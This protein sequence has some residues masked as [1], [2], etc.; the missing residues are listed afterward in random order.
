MGSIRSMKIIHSEY[1][2]DLI[3]CK[4]VNCLNYKLSSPKD[5][6]STSSEF[7]QRYSSLLENR[8]LLSLLSSESQSFYASLK[9]HNPNYKFLKDVMVINGGFEHLFSMMELFTSQLDLNFDSEAVE[10]MINTQWTSDDI[11]SLYSNCVDRL[12]NEEAV[13]LSKLRGFIVAF[14]FKGFFIRNIGKSK[15]IISVLLSATNVGATYRRIFFNTVMRCPIIMTAV[16]SSFQG[17]VDEYMLQNS[18]KFPHSNTTKDFASFTELL[19]KI[20]V[21]LVPPCRLCFS[22]EAFSSSIDFRCEAFLYKQFN[23]SFIKIPYILT[24]TF[25]SKFIDEYNSLNF[26]HESNTGFQVQVRREHSYQDFCKIV[27]SKGPGELKRPIKTT[28]EKEEGDDNLG[29]SRELFRLVGD[30]IKNDDVFI[31]VNGVYF[32]NMKTPSDKFKL[33]GR[34]FGVAVLGC[35]SVNIKLP[36]IFLKKLLGYKNSTLMDVDELFPNMYRNYE[37]YIIDDEDIDSLCLTMS[38]S[39]GGKDINIIESGS[40]ID[41]TNANKAEYFKNLAASIYNNPDFQ[42]CVES[43]KSGLTDVVSMNLICGTIET[44]SSL[45]SGVSEIDWEKWKISARCNRDD[46]VIKHFWSVFD[47]LSQK[48]KLKLLV[49]ATSV[50]HVP[51]RGYEAIAVTIT[52]EGTGADLPRAHTCSRTLKLQRYSSKEELK[53]KLLQ[54]IESECFGFK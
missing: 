21:D 29:V 49:F 24:S 45:L 30:G 18:E 34:I 25:I 26:E 50:D 1:G 36:V 54:A 10:L 20:N 37:K 47:E 9:S 12:L 52:A 17:L 19:Y 15:E 35:F 41:V 16:V 13:L 39:I 8:E 23:Y 22:N 5:G 40:N 11:F 46:D 38:I 53:S 6:V 27:G 44:V 42:R 7:C 4:N 51:A 31:E 32:P 33:V 14:M 2:C 48:E 3:T 28:F 43:F